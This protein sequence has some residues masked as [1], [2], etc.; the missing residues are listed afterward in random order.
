MPI[1]SH[2]LWYR[3]QDVVD[4]AIIND[5]TTFEVEFCLL[6]KRLVIYNNTGE[7]YIDLFN[8]I[9]NGGGVIID[10]LEDLFSTIEKS[11]AINNNR[12]VLHDGQASKR[13]MDVISKMI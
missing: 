11:E 13:I 9:K 10:S 8:S 1:K 4:V 5:P 3:F 7:K 2:D 6:N 12:D